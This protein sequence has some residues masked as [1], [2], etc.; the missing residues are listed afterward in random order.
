MTVL[1]EVLIAEKASEEKLAEAKETAT[2]EILAAKKDQ[3]DALTAE[4]KR[5]ADIETTELAKH[6]KHVGDLVE[7]ITQDAQVK[8][9]AVDSKFE[10]KSTD[11]VKKIKATLS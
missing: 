1:D 4:K 5:L 10:Q 7:K 3:V 6:T 11:L 2:A 8:V 9:H